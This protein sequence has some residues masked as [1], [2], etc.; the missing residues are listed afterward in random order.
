MKEKVSCCFRISL[1]CYR[2]KRSP[3]FL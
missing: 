3:R 1:L 2:R